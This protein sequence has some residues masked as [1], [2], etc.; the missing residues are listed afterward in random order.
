M[1]THINGALDKGLYER[2][3]ISC[4]GYASQCLVVAQ[5]D[6]VTLDLGSDPYN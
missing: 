4:Q 1:G 5:R 2:I 3:L 6:G